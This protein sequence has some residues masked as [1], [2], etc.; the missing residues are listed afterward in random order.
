MGRRPRNRYASRRP[1]GLPDLQAT[2]T[3][4]RIGRGGARLRRGVRPWPGRRGWP[5]HLGDP[6]LSWPNQREDEA[7]RVRAVLETRLGRCGLTL[8]P[9][10]T[11]L[12]PFGRP[13][14]THQS[15]QGPAT[16]DLWGC[17]CSWR[18]T[19]PGHWRM[20]GKTR[21]ASLRRAKQASDAWGR[22]HRQQPVAAPPAALGRRLRGPCNSFGVRGNVRSLRRRV[23]A[24]KRA[25][26]TWLGRRSQRQRLTWQ[27][28][29]DF[30]RQRP[31]PRPRI[32]VR[33]WGG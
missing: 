4:A 20:G 32:T 22:R 9:D 30:L 19:R 13:S 2:T 8:P 27:R 29:T 6:R 7:R 10:K 21:R 11:R 31:R 14:T 24:T 15:G 25:C 28:W 1:R 33:R 3:P 16:W 26:S 12:W 17:T 18:R 23:E 5:R